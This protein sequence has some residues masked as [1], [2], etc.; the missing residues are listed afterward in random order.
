ML[1]DGTKTPIAGETNSAYDKQHSLPPP[2]APASS[3]RL[4]TLFPCLVPL[5]ASNGDPWEVPL[6]G[7]P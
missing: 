7:P 2:V 5:G 3:L 6:S 4:G 1:R